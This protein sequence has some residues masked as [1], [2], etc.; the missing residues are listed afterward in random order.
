MKI[1]ILLAWV[2]IGCIISFNDWG[3][4]VLKLLTVIFIGV[5]FALKLVHDSHVY[6]F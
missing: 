6:Y 2:H 1:L 5:C 4:I 3:Y